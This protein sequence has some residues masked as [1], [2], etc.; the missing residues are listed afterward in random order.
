MYKSFVNVF[1]NYSTARSELMSN[2]KGV[3]KGRYVSRY[4][5]KC[6][7]YIENEC[8]KF[9]HNIN[10]TTYADDQVAILSDNSK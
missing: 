7:D 4:L 5:F 9:P 3:G 6:W 1:F 8:D 10:R 2:N